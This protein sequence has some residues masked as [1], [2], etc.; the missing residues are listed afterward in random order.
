MVDRAIIDELMTKQFK[1]VGL[2]YSPEY[3]KTEKW[4]TQHTWTDKQRT[5]F[6]K[7]FTAHLKKRLGWS[8][9]K[10]DQE[11]MWWD[12]S[13]GWSDEKNACAKA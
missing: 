1:I 3:C 7:W 4:Y 2:T 6:K 13:Y 10:C 12:L 9:S 8:K 11:F 5:S